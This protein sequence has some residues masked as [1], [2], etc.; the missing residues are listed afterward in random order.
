MSRIIPLLREFRERRLF[1]ILVTY[2]AAG[3]VALQ[4]ISQLVAHGLLPNLIYLLVLI[5]YV[6]GLPGVL[7]IGWYH[8]E[9]GDQK[10]PR[11]EV[12]GLSVIGLV[13]V[14][15]SSVAISNH[16]ASRLAAAAAES[17]MNLRRVAVLY[18][19]DITRGGELQFMADG[20][21][22]EL[23][24]ELDEVD[25]LEVVSSYGTA[26][27]RSEDVA[28]D[29][30][31]KLLNA[32]TL[33]DGTVERVGDRARINVRVMDGT[34]A[35]FK[36]VSFEHPLN[37][38]L[39]LQRELSREVSRLLREWL[40]DE[41]RLRQLQRSTRSSVAWALYNRAE[42]ARKDAEELYHHGHL[43]G[44]EGL[45]HQADSLLAEAEKVDTAWVDPVV[46]R[47]VVA[48][49]QS[50]FAHDPHR[51]VEWVQRGVAHA[52]R[53]LAR[54][55][56]NAQALEVRGSLRY[57]HH[58]LEIT[59]DP[60]EQERLLHS[61]RADLERAVELDE[62]LASAHYFLSHLYF[63]TGDKTAGLLAARRAY[64]EDAYL[65]VADN[66]LWR[67]TTGNY[68]FAE[69][70]HAQRWCEEGAERFPTDY[71]FAHCQL[72][73]MT[74]RAVPADVEQAWRLLAR[75]DSL[76]PPAQREFERARG[77]IL[78]SGV[79]AR[80]G[81]PDSARAVLERGY[82][83]ASPEVDPSHALLRLR[84]YMLSQLGEMDAAVEALKRYA[85]VVPQSS[86]DH[87]WWWQEI[88]SHPRFAELRSLAD[89]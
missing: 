46:L 38:V 68:D 87:H 20:L 22:E 85:A 26:P 58:L 63:R 45:F 70:T 77:E 18:F 37:D 31:A 5:W 40:G 8:G 82:A 29:S 64:E 78:V 72:L 9:R 88:R 79:I 47:A 44:M 17:G 43:E 86:F 19:Q 28:P 75:Q 2:L 48:Y 41:I 76:T 54:D 65:D 61:G 55:A 59:P 80:A 3:W 39:A 83:R 6:G 52:N 13:L 67:L 60:A 35:E 66:V 33:V 84:A 11:L 10:A 23:I 15:V 56:R 7:M 16:L 4:V 71:R 57:W 53:A 34:G 24:A 74:T 49:K 69:F 32:G 1:Q 30:I 62:S 27:F 73:M 50:R 51:A 12:F 14:G 25:E 42:K 36:R 89:H 21:T 81:L